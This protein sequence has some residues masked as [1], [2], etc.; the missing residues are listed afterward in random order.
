MTITEHPGREDLE[1]TVKVLEAGLLRLVGIVAS[2]TRD[3]T[4]RN[5]LH[6]LQAFLA[7][8]GPTT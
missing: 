3:D 7:E 2:D 8:E 1:T 5:D 4:V 6:D